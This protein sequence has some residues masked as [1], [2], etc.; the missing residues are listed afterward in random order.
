MHVVDPG[1][2]RN[3]TWKYDFWLGAIRLCNSYNVR[4]NCNM[5]QDI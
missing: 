1:V 2:A 4:C 5:C 3:V